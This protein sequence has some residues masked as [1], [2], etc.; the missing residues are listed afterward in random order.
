MLE[1]DDG[2]AIGQRMRKRRLRMHPRQS[3]PLEWQA[4]EERRRIRHGM[5]GRKCV[6][7][8]PGQSQLS[9]ADCTAKARLRLDHMHGQSGLR[10]SDGGCEAIRARTYDNR[11]RMRHGWWLR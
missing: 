4:A 6:V 8:E 7:H 3:M 11:V 5:D 1:E 9:R 10:Q 2:G